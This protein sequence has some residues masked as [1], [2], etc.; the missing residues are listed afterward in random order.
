MRVRIRV[1]ESVQDAVI[2]RTHFLIQDRLGSFSRN[3]EDIA[4]F[5]TRQVSRVVVIEELEIAYE[6]LSALLATHSHCF[7]QHQSM[8]GEFIMTL[9]TL[10]PAVTATALYVHLSVVNVSA[11]FRLL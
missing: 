9:A 8:I 7:L 4:A 10:K 1:G 3:D 6:N 11:H 5:I 2:Y